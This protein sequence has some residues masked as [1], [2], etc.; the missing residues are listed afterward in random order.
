MKATNILLN[1]ISETKVTTMHQTKYHQA[2]QRVKY[3]PGGILFRHHL[4][5][6]LRAYFRSYNF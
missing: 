5:P 4:D 3:A 6:F 2:E 1:I